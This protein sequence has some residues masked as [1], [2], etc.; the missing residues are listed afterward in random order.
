[1]GHFL[2]KFSLVFRT[3]QAQV[4][5]DHFLFIHSTSQDSQ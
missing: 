1:M 4:G 5:I 3:F 2:V